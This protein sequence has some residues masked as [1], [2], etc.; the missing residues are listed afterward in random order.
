MGKYLSHQGGN[1]SETDLA[2][3]KP[4]CPNGHA[5]LNMCADVLFTQRSL[6]PLPGAMAASQPMS[7]LHPS[8]QHDAVALLLSGQ[9][10]QK[11]TGISMDL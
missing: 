5:R 11:M 7:P 3:N 1:H 9:M 10:H 4:G 2:L 6:D 8:S